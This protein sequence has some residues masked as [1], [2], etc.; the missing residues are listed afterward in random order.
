MAPT[1]ISMTNLACRLDPADSGLAIPND[2]VAPSF[3]CKGL[4]RHC[5]HV[6]HHPP[7][8]L[9]EGSPTIYLRTYLALREAR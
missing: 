6:H 3:L 7:S 5:G 4:L 2:S 9:E 8:H 1:D